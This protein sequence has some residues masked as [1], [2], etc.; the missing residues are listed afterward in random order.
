[1]KIIKSDKFNHKLKTILLYIANDSVANAKIFNSELNLKIK[2]L[3]NFPKK[4]RN[5]KYYNEENTH[6]LIF[7]GYTIPY[8]I[9]F[10]N[11]K[12]VILTIFNQNLP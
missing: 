11:N 5:S 2:D 10:Q 6:D 12:I 8:Y 4:F 1:M 3:I 9:D 7:K